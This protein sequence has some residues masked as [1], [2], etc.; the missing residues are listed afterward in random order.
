MLLAILSVEAGQDH[1][2][3]FELQ[4]AKPALSLASHG[5]V[6]HTRTE[7]A[8]YQ[9][10]KVNDAIVKDLLLMPCKICKSPQTKPVPKT[11]N[12]ATA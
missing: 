1:V 6:Q 3:G 5:E 2:L 12:T 8:V 9:Q 7:Q 4:V 11:S 10:R